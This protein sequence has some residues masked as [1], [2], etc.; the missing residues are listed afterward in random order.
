MTGSRFVL[1]GEWTGYT[2]SQ[3]HVVHREV[4]SEKRAA[5]LRNRGAIRFRDNT[6]LI[7]HIR[8]CKPRE[9]VEAIHSYNALISEFEASL[10]KKP[11][12]E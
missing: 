1:E 9:K 12:T 10:S 8:P 11:P 7:L 5:A 6:W 3:R 4:I 2:A